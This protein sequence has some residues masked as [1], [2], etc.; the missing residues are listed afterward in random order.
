MTSVQL[1]PFDPHLLGAGSWRPSKS[2]KPGLAAEDAV[3]E[4]RLLWSQSSCGGCVFSG[5]HQLLTFCQQ[6]IPDGLVSIKSLGRIPEFRFWGREGR[7][8]AK[9][10][11]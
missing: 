6:N 4:A 9:V 10:T 11:V 7:K 1:A 3:R 5:W 8:L 2:L